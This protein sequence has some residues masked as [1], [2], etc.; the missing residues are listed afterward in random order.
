[1]REVTAVIGRQIFIGKTGE[2][3]AT[4]VK[5]PVVKKFID[6]YGE[7]TYQLLFKRGEGDYE[8]TSYPCEVTTD[9]K[10][11]NWIITSEELEVPGLAQCELRYLVSNTIAK[12][13][14]YICLINSS[15]EDIPQKDWYDKVLDVAED[16][17][18]LQPE[19]L[20]DAA[21]VENMTASAEITSDGGDPKVLVEKTPVDDHYNFNFKFYTFFYYL[22]ILF[23]NTQNYI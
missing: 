12:S 2:N 23:L 11:V 13:I 4:L 19:V 9:E 22:F 8:Q 10:N 14:T 7:G 18:L 5:F 15:V 1:M 6:L 16:I 20:E 21:M 3:N 17:K